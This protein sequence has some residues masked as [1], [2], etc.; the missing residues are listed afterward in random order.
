M[1]T[2]IIGGA[3]KMGRWF[4]RF[5]LQEGYDVIVSDKDRSGLVSL[6]NELKVRTAS[7]A[8][9]AGEAD[10]ILLAVNIDAFEEV[11]K[12]VAP[13]VR[14]GQIVIDI[15][16]VKEFPV[17][18]MHRYL[19]KAT[20]LGTHPLFGPGA[21][22]LSSQNLVITPTSEE[23]NRLAQKALSFLQE[24][25]ARVTLMT[26]RQHDEMM[27]VV[28]GLAHFISIVA[29]DTLIE[30]GNLQQMKEIGGSTYRVLTTLVES[31]VSE[32][33][34]LYATLQMRLP[35]VRE[36]EEQFQKNAARWLEMVK[37][38]DKQGFVSSM[39]ALKEKYAAGSANFGQAYENMY[40]I[41]EWL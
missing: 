36:V 30:A 31:V 22:A 32:D 12:E 4:A 3:G 17:E 20:V 21:K 18:T 7:S 33:P 13:H 2:G 41:M 19:D 6:E 23:E 26:P 35:R 8:G 14:K 37:N 24:R 34:E 38:G 5:L 25:G 28:L 11:V 29:A 16:S 39:T 27:S 9:T 15:T 10:I 1:K 40:K